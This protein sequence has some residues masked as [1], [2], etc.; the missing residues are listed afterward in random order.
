MPALAFN[1]MTDINIHKITP[2]VMTVCLLY[3]S[4]GGMKAVVYTDLIQ[5]I[6][7]YGTL[8]VIAVK[9]TINAGGFVAVIEKNLE[10]GRFE[11][12]E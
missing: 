2:I 9:G 7:M 12:P 5:I 11:A 8:L 6:I 4:L 1:Q 10:S 3:C